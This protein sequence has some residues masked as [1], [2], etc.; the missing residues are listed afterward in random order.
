[1]GKNAW[2]FCW[3]YEIRMLR[4]YLTSQ[5]NNTI[6]IIYTKNVSNGVKIYKMKDDLVNILE[7][8]LENYRSGILAYARIL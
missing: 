1:M 3:D 4:M 2:I 5:I 6:K 7:K 8:C